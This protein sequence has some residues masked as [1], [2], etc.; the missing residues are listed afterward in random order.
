[1][2][3][4]RLVVLLFATVARTRASCSVKRDRLPRDIGLRPI[5]A[6]FGF[7]GERLFGHGAI[8]SYPLQNPSDRATTLIDQHEQAAD[9]WG[10]RNPW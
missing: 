6:L 9:R 4:L 7:R 5:E 3:L 8:V 2:S 10:V 1:V